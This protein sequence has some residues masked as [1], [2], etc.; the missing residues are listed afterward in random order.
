MKNEKIIM[1]S[2]LVLMAQNVA[3]SKSAQR[4]ID[5]NAMKKTLQESIELGSEVAIRL[6]KALNE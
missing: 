2:M 5:D 3:L 4:E 1:E 6:H